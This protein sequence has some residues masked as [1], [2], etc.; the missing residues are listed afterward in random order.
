MKSSNPN[1]LSNYWKT[2]FRQ[3][4]SETFWQCVKSTLWCHIGI[5]F[6]PRAW[7][8]Q[9][10]LPALFVSILALAGCGTNTPPAPTPAPLP[11]TNAAPVVV[12]TPQPISTTDLA[13]IQ[14]GAEVASGAVLNFA[15]NNPT[16][17]TKLANEMY[18]AANAIY[19]LS[20]G[21]LPTPAQFSSTILAFGGS[22]ADANYS[23]FTT[24]IAGLYAAYYAKYN[25]GNTSNATAVLAALAAG[26][27]SATQSYVTTPTPSTSDALLEGAQVSL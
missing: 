7:K 22:Q 14:T 23:S 6:S 20:T 21:T 26:I 1:S 24:G 2:P 3:V 25:T 15:V 4:Y 10:L 11:S 8:I 18:S 13:L 12:V 9:S 5:K 27:Q 17:R 19:S 16:S